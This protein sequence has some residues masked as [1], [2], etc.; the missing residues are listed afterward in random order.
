MYSR[1]FYDHILGNL[2]TIGY[3][4]IAKHTT[5]V[6]QRAVHFSQFRIGL[7]SVTVQFQTS[8]SKNVTFYTFLRHSL[9][10][11]CEN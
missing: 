10:L 7:M 3:G 9:L 4:P 6:F 1:P 11:F 2:I 5:L 8:V